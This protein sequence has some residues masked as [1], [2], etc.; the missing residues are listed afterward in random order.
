MQ[1]TGVVYGT[2]DLHL[3][4]SVRVSV[5]QRTVVTMRESYKRCAFF[6]VFES[7]LLIRSFEEETEARGVSSEGACL[8]FLYYTRSFESEDGC[9]DG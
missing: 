5:V 6:N 9:D 7:R 2:V 1:R 4:V 3:V 8:G